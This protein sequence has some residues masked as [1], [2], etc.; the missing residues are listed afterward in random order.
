MSLSVASRYSALDKKEEGDGLCALRSVSALPAASGVK[1]ENSDSES[2][3][4]DVTYAM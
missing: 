4:G 3:P 1:S 2:E